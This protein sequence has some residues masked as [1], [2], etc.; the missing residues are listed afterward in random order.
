MFVISCIV[1]GDSYRNPCG[2]DRTC[3]DYWHY[4]CIGRGVPDIAECLTCGATWDEAAWEPEDEPAVVK[5]RRT[6]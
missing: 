1:C 3:P 6:T 2:C 4:A 5:P